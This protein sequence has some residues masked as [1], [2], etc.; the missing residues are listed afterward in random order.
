[1]SE[2]G[3]AKAGGA[4][5]GRTNTAQPGA[6][7]DPA[8]TVEQVAAAVDDRPCGCEDRMN[9]LEARF[10]ASETLMRAGSWLM[11]AAAAAIIYIL[12]TGGPGKEE[13]GK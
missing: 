6:P 5:A 13:T 4:A 9:T 8:P 1:M 12:W 2:T 10:A 11:I 3:A 7:A